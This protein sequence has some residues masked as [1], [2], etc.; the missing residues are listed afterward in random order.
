[1]AEV[2][3][4]SAALNDLV[5]RPLNNDLYRVYVTDEETR[6]KDKLPTGGGDEGAKGVP[7]KRDHQIRTN[8][9]RVSP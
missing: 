3:T 7:S 4:P 6:F 1:M 8:T 5:E 9:A 2:S